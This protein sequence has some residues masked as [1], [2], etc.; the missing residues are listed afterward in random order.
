MTHRSFRLSML[1]G[2]A[3]AAALS[4]AA[5]AQTALQPAAGVQ[6]R[7]IREQLQ[8]SQ[9]HAIRMSELKGMQVRNPQGQNLGKIEDLVVHSGSG[10]IRYAIMAF[11]PGIF[12]GER[13]FLLPMNQ[14]R[15]GTGHLVTDLQRERLESAQV[16]RSRWNASWLDNPANIGR[17]D[18]AWGTS[19]ATGQDASRGAA[20]QGRLVRASELLGAQVRGRSGEGLGQVEELVLDL[21]KERVHYTIVTFDPGWLQSE[22]RVALPVSA[23]HRSAA[24]D[25]LVAN[26]T[27]QQAQSMKGFNPQAYANLNDRKFVA[28]VDRYLVTIPSTVVIWQPDWLTGSAG[29][30]QTSN[31]GSD[32]TQASSMGASA[33]QPGAQGTA[34]ADPAVDAARSGSSP[35]ATGTLGAGRALQDGNDRTMRAPLQDR[36]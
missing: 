19:A 28:E 17:I 24:G 31:T 13:L 6:Q 21:P 7:D 20:A 9:Y 10:R 27:R 1:A 32:S 14:L 5:Q 25:H 11:D 34:A 26:I 12:S 23:L 30:G 4:L 15:M 8:P 22:K 35:P 16:D 33:S 2:A 3:V 29:S 36:N 18:R